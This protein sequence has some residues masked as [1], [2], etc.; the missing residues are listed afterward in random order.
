MALGGISIDLG[1]TNTFQWEG[2]FTNME[3]TNDKDRLYMFPSLYCESLIARIIL[4]GLSQYITNA[5]H[6]ESIKI[7][8]QG[9]NVAR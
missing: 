2:K 4:L 9:T 1:L 7:K 6:I 8:L 5:L 3:S